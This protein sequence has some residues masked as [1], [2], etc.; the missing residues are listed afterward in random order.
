MVQN[1]RTASGPGY[2]RPLNAPVPVRVKESPSQHPNSLVLDGRAIEIASI[3]DTWEIN[4]EWWRG[5]PIARLY[6][7]VVTR[8]G[9]HLTIFRDLVDGQWY[10][11]KV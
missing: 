6:Y 1:S 4:D 2:L 5:Q 11:Q 3:A 8:E 10:R 9:R 7:R